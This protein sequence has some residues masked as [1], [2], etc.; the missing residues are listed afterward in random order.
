MSHKCNVYTKTN[1]KKAN[2]YRTI[3]FHEQKK[4]FVVRVHRCKAALSCLLKIKLGKK[5]ADENTPK[6]KSRKKHRKRKKK[7]T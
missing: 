1:K 4:I 7:I 2:L 5:R 3:G 6:K